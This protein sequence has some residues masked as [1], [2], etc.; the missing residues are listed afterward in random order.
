MNRTAMSF[1]F[2]QTSLNSQSIL[3]SLSGRLTLGD[4]CKQMEQAMSALIARERQTLIFDLSELKQIDSTGIGR[5]ID[6]YHRLAR[7]GGSMR[8]AGAHGA[9][10]E[11]FRAT[12]LDSVL[13]FFPSV[14]A[15]RQGLD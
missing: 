6:A 12:R 11:A 5:F 10:R 7:T 4:A 3:V 1:E 14:E 15:A 9:V 8:L 2:R 13:P